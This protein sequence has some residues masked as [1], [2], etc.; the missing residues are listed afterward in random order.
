MAST[1]QD[2][3]FIVLVRKFP[4]VDR[5]VA[6]FFKVS[7]FVPRRL[8]GGKS[9]VG[10]EGGGV[11]E[12]CRSWTWGPYIKPKP[13]NQ[14]Q[15]VSCCYKYQSTLYSLQTPKFLACQ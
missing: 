7:Q 5:T 8:G 4:G 1:T 10:R 3:V 14:A 11:P 9:R 2:A 13:N 15:V 12:T 6:I